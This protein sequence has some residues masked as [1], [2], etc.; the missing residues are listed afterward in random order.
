MGY[1]FYVD[2]LMQRYSLTVEELAG[3]QKSMD[4]KYDQL[5]G[6][7]SEISDVISKVT[8]YPTVVAF[9][10]ENK[11]RLRSVR[12]VLVEEKLALVVV[13]TDAGV[14]KNRQVRFSNA[15]DY[16]AI[17]AVSSFISKNLVGLC[18]AD[19][20]PARMMLMYE[21]MG[22]YGELLKVVVSF[23]MEC[24]RED[25]AKVYIGG[26]SNILNNPEFSDIDRAREFF[27]FIDSRENV[28]KMLSLMGNDSDDISIKIG[29]E[30]GVDEMRD[31][32]IVVANYNVGDKLRGK[33]G[34]IGPTR[35]DYARVVSSLEMIN[36]RL[37]EIL[38]R[39]L[40][41]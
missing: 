37:G 6:V 40:G 17:D 33:I 18:A 3:L 25:C 28:S 4:R 27:S 11:S 21:A 32:S 35:M 13:V 34:I 19:I 16:A 24:L 39:I 36:D 14:V 10:R 23:V 5:E 30:S 15:V 12:I 1:R 29:S 7:I 38:N 26:A 8:H 31:T 20:T 9:P 22:D 2:S 41:Q